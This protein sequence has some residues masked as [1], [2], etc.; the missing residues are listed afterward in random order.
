MNTVPQPSLSRRRRN[1]SCAYGLVFI[2]SACIMTLELVAARLVAQHLGVSLYTWTSVIGVI[3]AGLSLGNYIGGKL[4]DLYEPRGLLPG[5][6]LLASSLSL[7]VL[8]LIN[9]MGSWTRPPAVSWPLWILLNVATTFL[10][11]SLVLGTIAPVVAAMTLAQATSTGSA[12]GNIYAWGALGSIVGTFATGFL[13]IDRYGTRAIVCGIALGLALLAILLSLGRRRAPF[14][15]LFAWLATI[16]LLSCLAVGPWQW[17][18]RWGYFLTL[19]PDQSYLDYYDE[20]NYFTIEIYD[21]ADLPNTKVLALDHLVHSYVPMDDPTRLEYPYETIYAA[22]TERFADRRLGLRALFIGG[23]GYVFPRYFEHRFDT[24]RIDVAEIDPAVQ[25]AAHAALLLPVISTRIRTHAIDARN[26]VDDWLR[27]TGDR[28]AVGYDFIYGDAFNDFGVPFHLT[29]K[30]FNDKLRRLLA[31]DGIYLITIIDIYRSGL[32]RFLGTYANTARQTFPYVYVFS[33][34]R[35]GPTRERD[36]FVIVNSLIR[37]PLLDLGMWPWEE[38][39]EG[40]LFAWM[41]NGVAGGAMADLLAGSEGALLTDDFAPVDN[42]L[43]PVFA[44]Q[45]EATETDNASP[46]RLAEP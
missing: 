38:D 44:A 33:G 17:A 14:G 12:I 31:P 35:D 1:L 18:Q 46:D 13:L 43:A 5:L 37:R 24:D 8:L 3:L 23:G 30:E 7:A 11:P 22:V 20:S 42:M 4:A 45:Q 16:S 39:F 6:L 9:L 40:R 36:T 19:R 34:D 41:E 25:Q 26:Y 27:D 32:G 2:T 21:A 15:V 29:T 10:L 28:D